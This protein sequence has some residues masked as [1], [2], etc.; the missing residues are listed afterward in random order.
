MI[1]R[2]QPVVK[3][4][5]DKGELVWGII[6]MPRWQMEMFRKAVDWYGEFFTHWLELIKYESEQRDF[7]PEM[8]YL[9]KNKARSKAE[10]HEMKLKYPR[11]H[12][13]RRK[14]V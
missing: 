3:G 6:A 9:D 13:D 10:I 7:N 4:T 11:K 14:R 2:T 1:E 8:G 5:D 12:T